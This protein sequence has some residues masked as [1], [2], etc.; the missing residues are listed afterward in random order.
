MSASDT[1]HN[2]QCPT[3]CCC[4]VL[5]DPRLKY[6]LLA[7]SCADR[8]MLTLLNI[9]FTPWSSNTVATRSC[10]KSNRVIS[11]SARYSTD[12][13]ADR[14]RARRQVERSSAVSCLCATTPIERFR[15]RRK[16]KPSNELVHAKERSCAF[17]RWA[18]AR[19]NMGTRTLGQLRST[20]GQ[21]IFAFRKRFDTSVGWMR[22]FSVVAYLL[23]VCK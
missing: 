1:C 23:R 16:Q 19:N 15:G 5:P 7:L 17:C 3:T 10:C 2:V 20:S 9:P 11:S 18:A 21:S 6:A 4:R 12:L 22:S 13:G 14:N 8:S